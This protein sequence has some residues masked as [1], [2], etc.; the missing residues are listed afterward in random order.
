MNDHVGL[1]SGEARSGRVEIREIDFGQIDA[2]QIVL[3][4][5]PHEGASELAFGSGNVD[6]HV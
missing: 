1:E 3:R 4:Q 5:S 6:T 2:E